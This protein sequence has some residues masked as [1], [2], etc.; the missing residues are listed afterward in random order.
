MCIPRNATAFR[1]VQL[2]CHNRLLGI[3]V[4]QKA[5][6]DWTSCLL[7]SPFVSRPVFKYVPVSIVSG[8]VNV[9]K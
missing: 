2:D 6:V 1:D 4:G 5:S 9:I 7:V 3:L 8:E